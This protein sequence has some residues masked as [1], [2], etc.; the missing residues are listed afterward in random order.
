MQKEQ[1]YEIGIYIPHF[2]EEIREFRPAR[3]RVIL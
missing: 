3:V 2:L 1:Y